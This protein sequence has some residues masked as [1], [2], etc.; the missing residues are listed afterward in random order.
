VALTDIDVGDG[1]GTS[2][3]GC[4]EE[5]ANHRG[6]REDRETNLSHDFSFLGTNRT[7]KRAIHD[8][9]NYGCS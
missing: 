9:L 2:D 8:D 7:R 5:N 1:R 4:R 6:K 3:A